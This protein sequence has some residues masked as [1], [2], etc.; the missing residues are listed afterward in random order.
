[1]LVPVGKGVRPTRITVMDYDAEHLEVQE[2]SQAEDVSRF[3]ERPTVTWID[4]TGLK[5]VEAIEKIGRAYGIHPLVLEDVLNLNQRPKLEIFDDYIFAVFKMVWL[6]DGEGL[7]VEQVSAIFGKGFVITFQEREGDVFDPLR[8]RIANGKGRVRKSGAD[9]LFYAILDIVIDNYFP[10]VERLEATLEELED[11]VLSLT[12]ESVVEEIHDLRRTVLELKR[13]AGPMREVARMLMDAEEDLISRELHPYLRDL[14]DHV[15]RVT[16][17]LE[18]LREGL[19]ALR[20]MHL[21]AVSNRMNEVMKTLT[22]IATV[23]MPLTF[24]VGVYGMNFE[25]MPEL[26]W[27]WGYPVVWGVMLIT[28]GFMIRYFR[29]KKWL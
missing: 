28:A 6:K 10:V 18:I 16:E 15:I 29:R 13:Y 27:R 19:S 9:Y 8:A 12:A 2:L 20:E 11:R 21:S 5:D 3:R 25:H 26:K 14:Y 17:S 22:I 24:I 4:V 1:V 23:F 7:E